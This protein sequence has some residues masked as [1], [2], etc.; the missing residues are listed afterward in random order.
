MRARRSASSVRST[1]AAHAAATSFTIVGGTRAVVALFE[2]VCE[3]MRRSLTVHDSI[4]VHCVRC[5]TP[6]MRYAA[7]DRHCSKFSTSITAPAALSNTSARPA[8]S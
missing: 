6:L 7:F 1:V 4:V 5:L 8:Y 3:S 2:A